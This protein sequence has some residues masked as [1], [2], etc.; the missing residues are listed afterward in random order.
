MKPFQIPRVK[1]HQ[2][3]QTTT[4][5]PLTKVVDIRKIAFYINVKEF[6]SFFFV[7]IHTEIKLEGLFSS[8]L[9]L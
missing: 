2:Y 9:L 3:L 5:C 1:I 7:R 4:S 6:I 8:D